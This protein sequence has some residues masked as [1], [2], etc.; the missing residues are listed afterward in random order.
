MNKTNL[1]GKYGLIFTLFILS[2]ILVLIFNLFTMNRQNN[3]RKEPTKVYFADN[4][5]VAHLEII[6][7]FNE[8]Y[9]N[10][11]EIVPINL[12]F[13]K[14]STNERKELIARSLRDPESRIDIFAVDQIWTPRFAKWGEPLAKYFSQKNLSDLLRPALSTCYFNQT[15]VGIPL[16]IDL[17]V[18]YYRRDLLKKLT[19]EKNFEA[20]LKR[21]IS[22]EEMI[23]LSS[24]FGDDGNFYLFQGDNYEG[25]ICNYFEFFFALGGNIHDG[26]RLRFNTEEGRKS[27]AFMV[28]L[29][30]KYRLSPPEVTTFNERDSYFWALKHDAPFFRGWSSFL[31]DMTVPAPDSAKVK[32]LGM[33]CLPHFD[34]RQPVTIFGGWNLM[35]SKYSTKK[36]EA[37]KFLEFILSEESQNTLLRY[38]G[39]LPIRKDIYENPE[40]FREFPYLTEITQM[41]NYGVHRP[42]LA[43]YTKISDILSFHLNK[44][45]KGDINVKTALKEVDKT[46]ESK[47]HF[48][49]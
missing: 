41:M 37:V 17:G 28:D 7:R 44:A 45:L 12:P 10:E 29:I 14:F 31:K 4:M 27:A 43:D 25:L 1:S 23:V 5:S 13:T 16:Y 15:L 36:M 30:H 32:L 47:Q 3:R 22:W 20:R 9:K 2:L 34:N 6:R 21:S 19:D 33:A 24:Q 35:I 40:I 26:N 42:P 39:Y 38:A 48:I 18:L 46:I 49:K 11:I 8:I